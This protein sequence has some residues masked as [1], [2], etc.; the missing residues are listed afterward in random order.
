[1]V[2]KKSKEQTYLPSLYDEIIQ[3]KDVVVEYK[4]DSLKTMSNLLINV[5]NIFAF[6]YRKFLQQAWY[7]F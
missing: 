5:K 6:R 3:K 7:I 4:F 2:P 1:M